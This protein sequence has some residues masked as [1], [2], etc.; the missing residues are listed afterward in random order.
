MP[1]ARKPVAFASVITASSIAHKEC[2]K[3]LGIICGFDYI[4]DKLKE[5]WYLLEYHSR[6]M[7]GDYSKRQGLNYN[8]KEE[9]L[10]A[11][12]RVRATA[13]QYVLKK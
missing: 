6:P 9:R 11:E 1:S 4:F 8:T 12:G 13:L 2:S 7:V 10:R 3:E 5:Q